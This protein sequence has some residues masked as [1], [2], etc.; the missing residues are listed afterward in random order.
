MSPPI[1]RVHRA[2]ALRP[3]SA[4][5]TAS[6]WNYVRRIRVQL[7][8]GI[9]VCVLLPAL[10]RWSIMERDLVFADI[11]PLGHAVVGTFA[12]LVSGYIL[13]RQFLTFPGVKATTYILPSF[14]M[15]YAVAA[16]NFFFLRF[17][18]S[19][20]QFAASFVLAVVWFYII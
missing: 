20:W 18:Y 10:V 8:G 11:S 14:V 5:S 19:R 15:S 13:L 3:D 6:L 9:V 2:I 12:A 17:E 4:G 16:M 1:S 7:G